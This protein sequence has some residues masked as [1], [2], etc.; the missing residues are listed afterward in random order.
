MKKGGDKNQYL[1]L[2]DYIIKLQRINLRSKSKTKQKHL[3][4]AKTFK[5]QFFSNSCI[6]KSKCR[7]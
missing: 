7:M 3:D 6:K 4:L 5:I 1:P 2:K